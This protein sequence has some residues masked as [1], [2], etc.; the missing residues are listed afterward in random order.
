MTRRREQ[1]DTQHPGGK[2]PPAD[3]AADLGQFGD[4]R[5]P[6]LTAVR[7]KAVGRGGDDPRRDVANALAI[8]K[9]H[10]EQSSRHEHSEQHDDGH[11]TLPNRG[12]NR[13]VAVAGVDVVAGAGA[14]GHATAVEVA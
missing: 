2:P 3:T 13:R 10:Q 1:R 11:Q 12:G 5:L 7:R 14:C 8:A 9:P 4:H 6:P